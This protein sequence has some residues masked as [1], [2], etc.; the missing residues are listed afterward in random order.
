MA[1]NNENRR[2]EG[3]QDMSAKEYSEWYAPNIFLHYTP[4]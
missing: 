4:V 1:A 3:L 2:D